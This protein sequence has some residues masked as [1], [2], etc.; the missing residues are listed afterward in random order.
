M[1]CRPHGLELCHRCFCDHRMTNNYGLGVTEFEDIH[2]DLDIEERTPLSV[3]PSDY[4]IMPDGETLCCSKHSTV[5][6]TRCFDF[7]KVIQGQLQAAGRK[8]DG[9]GSQKTHRPTRNASQAAPSAAGFARQQ[10][11]WQKQ[12]EAEMLAAQSRADEVAQQLLEMELAA[13]EA[14]VKAKEKKAAKK[15]A[16]KAK[17]ADAALDSEETPGSQDRPYHTLGGL[18]LQRGDAC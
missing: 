15:K 18:M 11:L 12:C 4:K 2:E 7:A 17:K 3:H 8:L 9:P 16:R 10:E 6:C 1:F 13:K 5:G 14:V